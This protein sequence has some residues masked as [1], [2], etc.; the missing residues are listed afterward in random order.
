MYNHKVLAAN[1][2]NKFCVP[3]NRFVVI[4]NNIDVTM[5]FY[6]EIT[7]ILDPPSWIGFLNFFEIVYFKKYPKNRSNW[8]VKHK[9]L[10]KDCFKTENTRHQLKYTAK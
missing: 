10:I 1:M 6:I 8:T 4:S 9:Y 2:S 7:A 5:T 3:D